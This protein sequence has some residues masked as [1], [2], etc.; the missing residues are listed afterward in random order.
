MKLVTFTGRGNLP[1]AGNQEEMKYG[2]HDQFCTAGFRYKILSFVANLTNHKY[3]ICI[4]VNSKNG[5][6]ATQ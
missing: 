2:Q 3:V 6:L 1:N 5:I 4:E